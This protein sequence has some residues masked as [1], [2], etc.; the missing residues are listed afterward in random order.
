LFIP[1]YQY[2]SHNILLIKKLLVSQ[3]KRIGERIR[4]GV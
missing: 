3:R 1:L 2:A 4:M